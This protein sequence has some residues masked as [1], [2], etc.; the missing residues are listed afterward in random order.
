MKVGEGSKPFA[1]STASPTS[2]PPMYLASS[3][4]HGRRGGASKWAW[5]SAARSRRLPCYERAIARQMRAAQGNKSIE[6]RKLKNFG[7][8]HTVFP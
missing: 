5:V 2:R 4:V 3:S 6:A 1:H 7:Q 8:I